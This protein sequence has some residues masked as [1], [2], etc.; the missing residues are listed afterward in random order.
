M[1]D[2]SRELS[3]ASGPL[4]HGALEP[5]REPGHLLGRA[6][7]G[8][9]AIGVI[10]HSGHP[11]ETESCDR[12]PFKGEHASG[13]ASGFDFD[14]VQ[15]SQNGNEP[16]LAF[17]TFREQLIEFLAD[18]FSPGAEKMGLRYG[19]RRSIK[20]AGPEFKIDAGKPPQQSSGLVFSGPAVL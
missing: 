15:I 5:P 18:G 13:I 20:K 11:N 7:L 17:L 8:V 4:V 1:A 10:P 2:P 19:C 9:A 6:F 14:F 12:Y 3:D 16:P